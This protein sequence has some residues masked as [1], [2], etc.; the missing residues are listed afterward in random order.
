MAAPRQ[1]LCGE[2]LRLSDMVLRAFMAVVAV[3]TEH[4]NDLISGGD[5]VADYAAKLESARTNWDNARQ[6]FVL[7]L[8]E[9]GC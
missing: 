6:A 8:K 2:K 9:H 7:H 1:A 4:S 5:G 3:Q